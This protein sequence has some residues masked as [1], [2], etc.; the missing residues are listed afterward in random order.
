MWWSSIASADT[1]MP[2]AATALAGEVDNIYA[3]LLLASFISCV[4]LIGG[5]IWFVIKYK[6]R[7]GTDKTP[8]ITHNHTLEFLW[9]FIPFVLFMF[10]FAWGW[11]VYHK[12]RTFPENAL[13]IH[14]IGK[15]WEWRFIYKNGKE[16]V[17]TIDSQ[18]Q[19]MPPEMVIP[20]G[21]PVKLIM[22]S[23]RL[24]P[25]TPLA[26]APQD[27]AVLH[28]FFIPAFRMKQDVVPGRYTA[29]WFLPEKMGDFWAFCAEYCGVSHYDMKAKVRV[30]SNEEFEKWLSDEGGGG[31]MSLADKG[32]A[33]Y[34]QKACVGCHT[35]DGKPSAGPTWKG[36]WGKNEATDKGSVKVDEAFIRE[37][38]LDPNAKVT[39]GF[40]PGIM[41]SMAGQLTE[42]DIRAVIE[43]IKTVK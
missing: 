9:S 22:A 21:R 24:N 29:I 43:F 32:K 20:I 10:V 17:S 13:E 36:L 15:K 35:L 16:V 39:A 2:P 7:T 31:T 12:M 33:I 14:V 40:Q 11:I 30:V 38:I 37:S 19:K 3:F 1:F 23:E 4:I 26:Q 6:R 27:R 42:D 5:M 34:A 28:S 25:G 8:Y 41:P 18:N